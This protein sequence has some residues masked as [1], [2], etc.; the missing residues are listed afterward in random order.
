M[1]SQSQTAQGQVADTIETAHDKLLS[2]TSEWTTAKEAGQTDIISGLIKR[3]L[4]EVLEWAPDEL[5]DCKTPAA[6]YE[7]I[8][9]TIEGASRVAIIIQKMTLGLK[10]RNTD[11]PYRLDGPVLTAHETAE[12]IKQACIVCGLKNTELAVL[13]NGEEWIVFRGS[14]IGDG[15]D[16]LEGLAFVF[17]SLHAVQDTFKLFYDLLSRQPVVEL[18]YR[19]HFQEAEG[20]PIRA[21]AFSK[22]LREQHQL[23]PLQ[24]TTLA[25]DLD[26]IMQSF[27]LRLA[28]DKDPGMLLNCFVTTRESQIAEEKIARISEDLVGRI[29]NLDT[30][31]GE[32][33][34]ELIHKVQITH[35]N[36]FVL[37]IGTKGAGK[38]TFIERFF[39]L[40]LD[41]EIKKECILIHVDLK[42]FEGA[43]DRV[44]DWLDQILLQKTEKAIFDEAPPSYEEIQGMFFDEYTRWSKGTFKHLY[45]SDKNQ[46]KIEFGRHIEKRREDRPH[47]YIC[48]LMENI[49]NSRKKA[50]C[51]VFDNADHFS[52]QFQEKVFQYAR[53][54]YETTV[55][56]VIMPI[57]DKTSWQLSRQGALQ[58][59]ETVSLYLPTPE[60]KTVLEQ[61]IKY[62]ESKVTDDNEERGRGYFLS[63]GIK[64]D[65]N[66]LKAFTHCL[67]HVFLETGKASMWVSNLSNM[68]IRRSLELTRDIMASPYIKV[69]ELLKAYIAQTAQVIPEFDVQRAIIRRNYNFYPVGINPFVQNIYSLRSEIGTSPLLGLRILTALHDA[70]HKEEMGK[71]SFVAVSQLY[72]YFQ[73]TTIERR[74]VSL[75]LD[76]LLHTGLCW[77][78][79]PT[80]TEIE[81]VQKIELSPSGRQHLFW[82]HSDDS[83]IGS[84]AEVTPIAHQ[85][86]FDKMKAV[87]WQNKRL[88]WLEKTCLFLDYLIEEDAYYVRVPDHEAYRGQHSLPRAI[89]RVARRLDTQLQDE[90]DRYYGYR[91]DSPR[92]QGY[93]QNRQSPHPQSVREN[94]GNNGHYP[95]SAPSVATSVT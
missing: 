61:R 35:L 93:D 15:K 59:F 60:P 28:G 38:S 92:R 2:V 95:D 57:T 58:S 37:L 8:R 76:A 77:S 75:W 53:S 21:R 26:R 83:Y 13:T 56:L 39:K 87:P 91:N 63:Y 65:L 30:H 82:G 67:Q 25:A 71:E 19:A 78:Y 86:T 80:Q 33:L 40:V 48:R 55:C 72:D 7:C 3:I 66:H 12:G 32:K 85:P 50:P 44:I 70:Q 90:Q 49:V 69:E 88:E 54:I 34:S 4:I 29:R 24:S 45:E 31:S 27:F 16:T 52:I 17:P 14:R 6:P 9:L 46:F 18:R 73:A 41:P 36:E 42:A 89:S 62:L 43:D 20:Q 51:I 1:P 84:M 94:S 64:L 79:D 74:V 23:H 81:K 11:R 68:D 22:V 5:T 47:E 10:D